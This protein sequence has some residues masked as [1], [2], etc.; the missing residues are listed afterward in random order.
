MIDWTKEAG[1]AA[2]N[3]LKRWSDG[4]KFSAGKPTEY[5]VCRDGEVVSEFFDKA[6]RDAALDSMSMRAV[7]DAAAKAQAMTTE[8]WMS[9]V[10][11]CRGYND[12]LEEA[13]QICE[14]DF[15]SE[16]R[17]YGKHFAAAIRKLGE[18]K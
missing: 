17:A 1:L 9:G 5:F 4:S 13:A 10:G 8:D 7:L 12:A 16:M 15:D 14:G 11:Y 6:D 18:T 2:I 3:E